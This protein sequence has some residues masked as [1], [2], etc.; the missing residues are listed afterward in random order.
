MVSIGDKIED[1][2]LLDADEDPV[3]LSDFLGKWVVVY[4]YPKDNTP[5]CTTEANEFTFLLPEFQKL[6]TV[7]L[8]IS[9]DNCKSHRKF[10]LKFDLKVKLLSDPEETVMKKLGAWG[11]KSMYGKLFDGVIRSTLLIDPDGKLAFRWS[12]VKAKGHAE[13]VKQKISELYNSSHE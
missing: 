13:I 1:F 5:G 11:K 2:E 10:V 8:G 12:N 7:V 9:P 4:F 6:N 3:R